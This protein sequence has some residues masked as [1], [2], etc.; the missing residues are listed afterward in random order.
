MDLKNFNFSNKIKFHENHLVDLKKKNRPFPVTVEIDITNHCNHRCSFC[1]WGEDIAT[2]KSSLNIEVLKKTIKDLKKKGTKAIVFTGGGEPMIHKGFYEILEFTK[3]NELEVG[4]I[5]NGSAIVE[6]KLEILVKNLKWLRV[7]MSGGDSKS[8]NLVQGKDH[9]EKVIGNINLLSNYKLSNELNNQ[10]K[11]GIRMLVNEDNYLT[12]ENLAKIAS[13]IRGL[14]YLQ[15]A[16]NQFSNDQGK[17]WNSEEIKKLFLKIKNKLQKDKIAFLGASFDVLQIDNQ[18]KKKII[19]VPKKCYAHFY[20]FAIMADGNVVFCKNSRFNKNF[21]IGNIYEKSIHEIW[22]SEKNLE[23]ES[24]IRPNN[25]G[26]I[27]K[28]ITVNLKV[29]EILNSSKSFDKNFEDK[30]ILNPSDDFDV[31]FVG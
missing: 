2:D 29:E 27:C 4:L 18:N 5:T 10:F 16:P 22:N 31:N 7:S 13:K 21:I 23:L 8:Y 28:N 14:N 1:C 12:L 24:W 17:F 9:F 11:I 30:K 20:Q 19:D 3:N 15:V 26:L 6:N 25:C